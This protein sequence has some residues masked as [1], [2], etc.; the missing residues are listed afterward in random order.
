METGH[1]PLWEFLPQHNETEVMR[2]TFK[3]AL[4]ELH[5]C[6]ANTPCYA[7]VFQLQVWDKP[8]GVPG[9]GGLGAPA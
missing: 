4:L 2:C 9:N 6:F 7:G 3:E 5:L 8:L 1:P